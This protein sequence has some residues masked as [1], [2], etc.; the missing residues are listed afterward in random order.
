[1]E[2]KKILIV[3]D[4]RDT[5][6]ILKLYLENAGY[7]VLMADNGIDALK[8]LQ[9]EKVDLGIYDIMMP[10]MDGYELIRQTRKISE[11]PILVLSAKHT[12]SEKIS[13]LNVNTDDYL[14]RPFNP[15]EV[16]ARVNAA[17]RRQ[18]TEKDERKHFL[19]SGDL[20]LDL[21]ACVLYRRNERVELTS[22]EYRI[23]ALLMA[24]PGW[25]Y[26][27][28][29]IHE[30]L[31]G[32]YDACNDNSLMVHICNLRRKIEDDPRKPEYLITVRGL[33]YRFRKEG[34]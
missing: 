33:G 6:K 12:D 15:L 17:L 25:V 32:D 19:R 2:Q 29:E 18:D 3:E 1:M 31:W 27:R 28:H 34:S 23:L 9:K 20:Y 26:A 4:A 5:A 24:H 7:T 8:L 11:I 21:D 16:T 14:S 13:G 30:M 22:T 10:R